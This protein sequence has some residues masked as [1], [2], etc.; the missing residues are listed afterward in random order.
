MVK[1]LKDP[2]IRGWKKAGYP[3]ELGCPAECKTSVEGHPGGQGKDIMKTTTLLISALLTALM[4]LLFQMK[5]S[6]W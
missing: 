2:S 5:R 3:L 6:S 1:I 4:T